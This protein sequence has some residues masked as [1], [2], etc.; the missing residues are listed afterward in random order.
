MSS[1][2]YPSRIK[3]NKH[4]LDKQKLRPLSTRKPSPKIFLKCLSD[5]REIIPDANFDF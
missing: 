4:L 5:P 3:S 1:K 2:K